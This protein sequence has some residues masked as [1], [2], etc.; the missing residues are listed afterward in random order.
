MSKR[1]APIVLAEKARATAAGIQV[2]GKKITVA[3]EVVG[4]F[5]VA[6]QSR[7]FCAVRPPFLAR[8][9]GRGLGAAAGRSLG[10]QL[11]RGG[12]PPGRGDLG[13]GRRGPRRKHVRAR[14]DADALEKRR[15]AFEGKLRRRPSQGRTFARRFVCGRFCEFEKRILKMAE[16]DFES[17]KV[18][19]SRVDARTGNAMRT[20]GRV[21]IEVSYGLILSKI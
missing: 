9:R 14:T 7:A 8:G 4:V 18:S 3:S 11:A 5:A 16:A 6:R 19:S 15:R 2:R 17:F 1:T 10:A 20:C 12:G 21:S 13:R